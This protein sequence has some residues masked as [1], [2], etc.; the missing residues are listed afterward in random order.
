MAEVFCVHRMWEGQDSC[1]SIH[2]AC[3]IR[4]GCQ[5]AIASQGNQLLNS[6]TDEKWLPIFWAFGTQTEQ[7]PVLIALPKVKLNKRKANYISLNYTC[8]WPIHLYLFCQVFVPKHQHPAFSIITHRIS[9]PSPAQS[10]LL[11]LH[12][13]NHPRCLQISSLC[14]FPPFFLLTNDSYQSTYNCSG[15][16]KLTWT[17]SHI[18]LSL[19]V[20]LY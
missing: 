14:N 5:F 19:G 18:L 16:D 13:Q 7:K 3:E 8:G 9:K 20:V 2:R 4:R 15:V 17:C 1:P 10:T 12:T 11:N 6:K